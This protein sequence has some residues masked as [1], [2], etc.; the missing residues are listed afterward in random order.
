MATDAAVTSS[1]QIKH[2]DGRVIHPLWVRVTHWINALA[3]IVMIGSGWQIY[4]ASPI[5]NFEFPEQI[6][7]GGWLAGPSESAL[8]APL[9]VAAIAVLARVA[10]CTGIDP[11]LRLTASATLVQQCV[12]IFYATGGR[13]YYLTWLLTLLVAAV[14]VR[15]E[16]IE[17]FRRRFP[18]FTARVAN[19][20]ASAA[21]ARALEHM[22]RMLVT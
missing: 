10:T 5:F 6:T 12:G 14:W 17:M 16:G 8:M 4:N 22:S 7:I 9:H 18:D 15:A 19:H 3:M 2:P 20:P 13:Y 1:S 11:W 21:L